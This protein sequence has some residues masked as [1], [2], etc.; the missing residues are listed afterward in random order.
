MS[1]STATAA[2]KIYTYGDTVQFTV[3]AP[4]A[5]SVELFKGDQSLGDARGW[6]ADEFADEII[7]TAK[8]TFEGMDEPLESAPVSIRVRS[9]GQAPAPAISIPDEVHIRDALV[10]NVDQLW[11]DGGWRVVY[12]DGTEM[13]TDE[14][15]T[16]TIKD[17]TVGTHGVHVD[18]GA[19]GYDDNFADYT[20]NVT[21][22]D[23]QPDVTEPTC[24]DGGYTTY[25]CSICNDSYTDDT[26]DPLGHDWC[27][28]VFDWADDYSTA[29]ATRTCGRNG[30]HSET[31]DA[32]VT[33]EITQ[34]ATCT[35]AGEMLYTAT[36]TFADDS[37]YTDNR[38]SEIDALGHSYTGE[39]ENWHIVW[40]DGEGHAHAERACDRCHEV[41]TAGAEVT[42]V[43]TGNC[44]NAGKI[45]YT[46]SFVATLSDGTEDTVT[47]EMSVDSEPFGHDWDDGVVTKEPGCESEGEKTFTCSR[48]GETGP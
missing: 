27:Q 18:F 45:T 43:N 7:F 31:E 21:D 42:S 1:V 28:P 32:V 22:H 47:D 36:V 8:A 10:L 26:V 6:T 39:H 19:V 34:E 20:V 15:N 3:T 29:T 11:L 30:E 17:P 4:M 12:V 40:D 38:T 2:E 35:T 48:C 24:T 44:E 23:Y 9:L 25:I 41:E 13:T 16:I 37:E 5:E 46:A 33:P 14:D